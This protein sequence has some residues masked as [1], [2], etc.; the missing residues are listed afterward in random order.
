MD[1]SHLK[2]SRFP[3]REPDEQARDQGKRDRSRNTFVLLGECQAARVRG[4]AGHEQEDDD[5]LRGGLVRSVPDNRV[6]K[7]LRIVGFE[8]CP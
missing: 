8:L 6:L 5:L 1:G 3:R 2:L 7:N 4:D